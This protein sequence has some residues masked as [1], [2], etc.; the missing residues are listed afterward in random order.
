[1]SDT[2]VTTE[3]PVLDLPPTTPPQPNTPEARTSDG[4]L[5]DQSTPPTTTTPTETK[6]PDPAKPP[7]A[8]ETYSD[9]K[10]PEGVTLK[11]DALKEAS[12]IF[13]ELG[14]TQDQAQRLVDFYGKDIKAAADAPKTAFDTM[15]D[16]WK[17][18]VLKDSSLAL[19]EGLRP[20][21]KENIG[22][23]KATLGSAAEIAEFDKLM[24]MSGLGNNPTIVK[25]LNAWGKN[26][27]EGKHVAGNGPSPLGQKAPAASERPSVA[28][29]IYPNLPSQR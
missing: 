9:F 12:G 4:T 3:P 14:L 24:N 27:G 13:K 17:A 22:K 6:T 18:D 10:V 19:G 1:M 20:D 5:K 2:T 26:L 28:S 23:L 25:A 15:V 8:P 7:A 16:G 29:S 11:P 21:V